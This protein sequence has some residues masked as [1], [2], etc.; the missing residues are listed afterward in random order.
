[1]P[2]KQ[3]SLV[4]AKGFPVLW[5]SLTPLRLTEP[6]ALTEALRLCVFVVDAWATPGKTRASELSAAMA[7]RPPGKSNF[8]RNVR[9]VFV[10]AWTRHVYFRKNRQLK[11]PIQT[12]STKCQ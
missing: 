9:G 2:S 6:H 5:T 10:C 8:V 7:R 11:S 3:V 4:L 12:M 1:M